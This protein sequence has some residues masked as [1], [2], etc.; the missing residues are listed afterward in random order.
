MKTNTKLI[1]LTTATLI[2]LAPTTASAMSFSD[3]VFSWPT[4][5]KSEKASTATST[6]DGK[7]KNLEIKEP[8]KNKTQTPKRK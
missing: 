4:D 6:F 5:Y 2:A 7:V 1:A 3:N 8:A